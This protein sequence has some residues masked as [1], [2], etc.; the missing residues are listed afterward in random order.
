MTDSPS[1]TAVVVAYGAEPEL[2]ECIDALL[3]SSGA[4]VDVV[5]VDNGDTSGAVDKADGRPGV[6]VVRPGDNTGFALGCNLGAE[7]ATGELVAL[8]NPDVEVAP[9]ALARLAAE[10]VDVVLMDIHMPNTDGIT[11]TGTI[12]TSPRFAD[13]RD[14]PILA[15]TAAAMAGDRERFLAAGLD[16]YVAKPFDMTDLVEE[17]E[18]ARRK[19]QVC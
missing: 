14:I 7:A 17:I 15:V 16:G 10:E 4:R 11:A 1:I 9:D 5:I 6:T 13:K 12:R 3:A 18:C 19:R 2:G 8:V